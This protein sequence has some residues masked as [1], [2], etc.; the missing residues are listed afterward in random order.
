MMEGSGD[1][2]SRGG[3]LAVGPGLALFGAVFLLLM[4]GH[5][6]Q[7][8]AQHEGAP[9]YVGSLVCRECHEKQYESFTTYAKKSTSFLSIKRLRKELT[10]EEVQGCY[11]C[12]TTGYGEPGGFVSEEATPHL[13]NA[14]CEVCHGPG[15][16]HVKTREPND[17]KGRLTQEDCER[18]H[19][20]ERVKAFRYKPLIHGGAH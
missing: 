14:G 1:M 10:E 3:C 15:G 2:D 9:G 7:A 18:C 17:I 6:L 11:S 12:H 20:S 19:T 13:K 8:G 5:V 16:S 4:W